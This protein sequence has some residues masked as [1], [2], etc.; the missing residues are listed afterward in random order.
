M[1]KNTIAKDGHS[2]IDPTKT[3]LL[4]NL[5]VFDPFTG[6]AVFGKSD[7]KPLDSVVINRARL[8]LMV[9]GAES[10]L[11]LGSPMVALAID[12]LTHCIVGFDLGLGSSSPTQIVNCLKHTIWSK[13]YVQTAYPEVKN[14]WPCWGVPKN[15]YITPGRD[16]RSNDLMM[17]ARRLNIHISI[18]PTTLN[19]KSSEFE[20]CYQSLNETL[21]QA[22]PEST[23][24]IPSDNIDFSLNNQPVVTMDFLYRILH[25]W[26]CDDYHQ[27]VNPS[28]L[29]TPLSL[30]QDA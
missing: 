20:Y 25:V 8:N 9:V 30:W 24:S 15:I 11:Q 22:L 16:S 23:L 4:A 13:S 27:R 3:S 14:P 2:S 6:F 26:V 21:V 17:L 28:T 19:N 7:C 5:L 12:R 1:K 18:R 10:N 29:R